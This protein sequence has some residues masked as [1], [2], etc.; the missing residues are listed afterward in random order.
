MLKP[1]FKTS[2]IL[3]V[4]L[5]TFASQTLA[6]SQSVTP[7]DSRVSQTK[8]S[9]HPIEQ[10]TPMDVWTSFQ[11]GFNTILQL[12][13]AM[14]QQ[15][16]ANSTHFNQ[17]RLQEN[18]K[19]FLISLNVPGVDPRKIKVSVSQ[20]VLFV[21]TRE[22][23]RNDAKQNENYAYFSYQMALPD[24]A[25]TKKM[26]AILKRGVLQITL[27]KTNKLAAMTE[28]PVKEIA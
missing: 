19:Q 22:N 8:D 23:K 3:A 15:F 16:F 4:S 1:T 26:S 27:E 17:F 10:S 9:N 2:M 21:Q 13:S 25:D 6:L 18:P 28:I 24:N 7:T 5:A 11:K 14:T 20:G 12:D